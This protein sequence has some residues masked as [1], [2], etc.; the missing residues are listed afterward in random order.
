MLGG[1]HGWYPGLIGT[2]YYDYIFPEISRR[3]PNGVTFHIDEYVDVF[4]W[5]L[6]DEYFL[7]IISPITSPVYK[8]SE[9]YKC[10]QWEGIEE[11]FKKE[12][13]LE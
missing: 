3:F 2:T 12:R 8:D 6:P 11:L 7:V 9:F 5:E 13:I 10:D 4:I 1:T